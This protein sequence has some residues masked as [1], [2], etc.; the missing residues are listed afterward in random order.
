MLEEGERQLSRAFVLR[1]CSGCYEECS[2]D[3]MCY[4]IHFIQPSTIGQSCWDWRLPSGWQGREAAV[5]WLDDAGQSVSLS[6]N[7]LLPSW[8]VRRQRE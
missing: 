3:S 4:C 2:E 5:S 1:H 6:N 7:R 8:S